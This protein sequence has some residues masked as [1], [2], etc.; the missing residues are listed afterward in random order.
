MKCEIQLLNASLLADEKTLEELSYWL[1]VM[2]RPNG[3][4]YDLDHIWILS[5]LEKAG[6]KPGATI[7]DAGAGQ[8]V[9]QYLLAS[10]GYNVISLDFSPRRIPNRT[11]GIFSINGDGSTA[12][13]YQHSYMG[14]INY[15]GGKTAGL[16]R[17]IS[18]ERLKKI[19]TYIRRNIHS[20][21]LWLK[22]RFVVNHEQYGHITYIRAPFHDIPLSDAVADAVVSVSA[23]EHADIELFRDN[24]DSLTRLLKPA[25][26]MLLTTSATKD[27]NSSYNETVSGWCFSRKHIV[28]LLPECSGELDGYACEQSLLNS[29]KFISRIDK[30][31]FQKGQLFHGHR[32]SNLP[33]LPLAIKFQ[34]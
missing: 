1:G 20:H 22:E 19:P 23:I 32:C 18:M 17:K 25:S 21:I 6:I 26:P 3:W 27:E 8:G 29:K 11:V 7:L 5:E 15:G 28:Q 4:H 10:R 12:I 31:Y 24:I 2:N 9:L 16:L 14:V 34:K 30:Y 33:Y 13:D